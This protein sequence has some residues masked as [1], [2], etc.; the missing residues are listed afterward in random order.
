ML[1]VRA[2][3]PLSTSF[4]ISPTCSWAAPVGAGNGCGPSVWNEGAGQSPLATPPATC[5]SYCSLGALC[6]AASYAGTQITGTATAG[7]EPCY[8]AMG[9]TVP[10][11]LNTSTP[12]MQECYFNS[13][14]YG[15]GCSCVRSP[16]GYAVCHA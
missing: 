15:N 3:S 12:T 14:G 11:C 7:C 5:P 10:N 4:E 6:A 2:P 9:Y 8:Q 13:A 16:Y 1:R